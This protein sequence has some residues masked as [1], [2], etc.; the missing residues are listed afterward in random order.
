MGD[1]DRRRRAR[2]FVRGAKSPWEQ[3]EGA[4]RFEK[5]EALEAWSSYVMALVN[6]A[7]K[8]A[9]TKHARQKRARKGKA[10]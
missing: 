4:A 7:P 5:R 9:S 1:P 3:G 8:V 2:A 10:S 6:P